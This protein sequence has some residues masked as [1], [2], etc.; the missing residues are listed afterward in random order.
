MFVGA[1]AGY[2]PS[3]EAVDET[4]LRGS[5]MSSLADHVS[6][7]LGTHGPSL[8]IETA[9]SSSLVALA[10]AVA[11]LR[12]GDCDYAIV[13]TTNCPESKDFHLSLQV[14]H[15]TEPILLLLSRFAWMIHSG[16]WWR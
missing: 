6:F 8:T 5:L 3:Q 11:S 13:A 10:M 16:W 4:T 15:L 1:Y 2:Q 14:R 9:C 12:K 7:F